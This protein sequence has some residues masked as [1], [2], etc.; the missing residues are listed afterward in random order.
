MS[1][2]GFWDEIR[3]I[4]PVTRFLCASSLAVSL[5][6]MLELVS[7]YRVVFVRELV[8]QKWEIWRV[9]SSFFLGSSGINFVFDFVMLYRN[10]DALESGNYAGRSADLAWQL[11][12][13]AGGILVRALNIPLGSFVHNRALVVC[14]T[15][16]SSAL[17]PAGSQSSL[18]GLV[19][20]PMQYLPYV[21]IGMDLIMGG[22][23]AAATSVTGA[24]VGHLW[25]WSIFGPDGQ[26]LPGVRAW[27]NAPGWMRSL[28]GGNA[29][30]NIAPGSGVHVVPPRARGQDRAGARA[31]GSTTGYQWGSGNRLGTE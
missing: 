12:L 30:P 15:Y 29:G 21:L 20:I 1:N 31:G 28:V 18:M 9:W 25:W 3:K 24:V 7:A 6:V 8:T 4:P 16:L 17:A 5:P 22:P 23:K 19:A 2:S 11:L 26:G 14:L 13:A 10:T 27:G